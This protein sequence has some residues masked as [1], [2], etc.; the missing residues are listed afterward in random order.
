LCIAEI[1]PDPKRLGKKLPNEGH[2]FSRAVNSLPLA[3][4]DGVRFPAIS[5]QP[6]NNS[7][8]ILFGTTLLKAI[9]QLNPQN[10]SC[11]ANLDSSA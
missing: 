8:L 5:P 7:N 10:A 11:S 9:K 3:A 1:F 6:P 2:G 4:L